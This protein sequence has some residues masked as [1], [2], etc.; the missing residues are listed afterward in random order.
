MVKTKEMPRF[1]VPGAGVLWRK[2]RL[3]SALWP[4]RSGNSNQR[5]RAATG[6]EGADERGDDVVQRLPLHG[7]SFDH[8]RANNVPALDGRTIGGKLLAVGYSL[9]ARRNAKFLNLEF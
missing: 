1:L 6:S 3:P 2:V 5:H 7:N 4:L 9:Y 8:H